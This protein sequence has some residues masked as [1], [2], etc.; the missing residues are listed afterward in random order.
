MSEIRE[1]DRCWY[2]DWASSPYAPEPVDIRGDRRML[3]GRCAEIEREQEA[4]EVT[5]E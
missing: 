1:C 3:C 5:A 4:R 2:R